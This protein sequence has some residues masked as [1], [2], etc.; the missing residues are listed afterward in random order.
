VAYTAVCST[1]TSCEHAFGSMYFYAGSG[2]NYNEI[3]MSVTV[4]LVR[5]DGNTF[6][7]QVAREGVDGF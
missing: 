3:E 6:T 1:A 4:S 5:S 2:G 7:F